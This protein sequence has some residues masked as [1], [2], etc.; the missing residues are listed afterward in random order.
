[1]AESTRNPKKK[2]FKYKELK[3]YTSTEWLADNKKKYRQVFNRLSTTYVYAE[4]SFF[5]KQFDEAD[6]EIDVELKCFALNKGRQ[7]IC[8]LPFKRKV[9]KYDHVVYIRE[10]WGSKSEGAFWKRGSYYWEA[11]IE[12]EKVAT[13][14]FYVEDGGD[15]SSDEYPFLEVQSLNLYEG[16]YDDVIDEGRVYYKSF[17][18]EDTRYI[19]AE[20]I[21]KNKLKTRD[22]QCELFAKFYNNSKELKGQVIRLQRIEPNKEIIKV[23]AGWG[24]NVKG[25][26]RK[27]L[28]TV[29]LIFMDKL[30]AAIPFTVGD[31]FEEGSNEVFLP[32]K[33]QLF[34]KPNIE[35]LDLS[36]DE[37]LERLNAL[38]GLTKIKR[39]VRDHAQY[40]KFLQ[41]RKEKG[42]EEREPINVH[43]AFIGNPGTGKTTVAKMMGKLYHKMGLLSK[44]HV[45]EVD[46]V[47]LVGEY[48]GQ[49]APK[50]KEAIEKARG[51]V[52]FIDEAYSLARSND[53]TKDFGRE[54]IEILVKELSNGAGNLAVIVAGYPQEMN[55][56]LNSNPG[57]KSRFKL[58]FEF[59]DYLPQQLIEISEYACNEK[60]VNLTPGARRL[61]EKIITDEFRKRDRTFGNARFVF[62]LI[63]K[64]KIQMGIRLMSNEGVE[65]LGKKELATIIKEDVGNISDNKEVTLPAIDIDYAQLA[66]NLKELDALIGMESIKAEIHNMVRLVKYFKASGKNVLNNFFLHTVFIGNPGTGKTTVARILTNI[67]RALGILERG[68]MIETDRQGLVAGYVGQTAI[69]TA[70][71]IDEAEG[72]V[73][74]IDE[75]YALTSGGKSAMGDFGDEAIQTLLKR[76]EDARGKFF[77]FVAGYPENMDSF[78]KANPGLKSRFDKT[79]VFEDY[80]PKELYDIA[81]FMLKE[82]GLSTRGESAKLLKA[83]LQRLYE[84]RD[85]FFGNARSVRKVVDELIRIHNIRL[86]NHL[87]ITGEVDTKT[88]ITKGDLEQLFESKEK[89][90]FNPKTIGFRKD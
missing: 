9:S 1:M 23:T 83:Y 58:F 55:H 54:V 49:T 25:S 28:Y 19:Y 12:G 38:I 45:H 61:L 30:M 84:T 87:E 40:I 4:L 18:S 71:K 70:K 27:D 14:Y 63:E 77:V 57:L 89:E 78:L 21:F 67:Y 16:P 64:S 76:M 82:K 72:G 81:Q 32:N 88:T 43:S 24:S 20:I 13:K 69:K 35:E 75:A 66:K 85:K 22:W 50:V 79:L 65:E 31:E 52:L 90:L 33:D 26:W 36:F 8:S 73:L 37:L 11:W 41:L 56:F 68:V 7:E 3:V 6:W 47:D 60:E 42:F 59:D 5:N 44:G 62:D 51:G 39:K 34:Q 29:E 74:F 10:G 86:A 17:S 15:A 80:S 46:R 53:D 2:Y 48:I